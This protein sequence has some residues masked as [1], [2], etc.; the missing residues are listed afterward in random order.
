[1]LNEKKFNPRDCVL[2][3]FCALLVIF[4]IFELYFMRHFTVVGVKGSSMNNTLYGGVYD[5]AADEYEGGDCLFV[6]IFDGTKLPSR[7]Q[8]VTID[9]GGYSAFSHLGKDGLIIKRLIGME[10]D[11]LYC[12]GGTVYRSIGGGEYE[13]LEEDYVSGPT[14][15]FPEV[16]LKEG[17]IFVLG[18]NRQDSHDSEELLYDNV[19]LKI[20]DVQG[21]VPEWSLRCKG[22]ITGW[23]NF[24][25]VLFGRTGQR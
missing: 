24:R 3:I 12:S 16:T 7:G 4:M 9:V 2:V 10:G 1:M 6:E 23:E 21:M 14:P 11:S 13:A 22:L 20:G 17:E 18:D 19:F 15:D 5:A 8:I 25:S